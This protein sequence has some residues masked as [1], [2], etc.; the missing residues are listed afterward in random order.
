MQSTPQRPRLAIDQALHETNLLAVLVRV[1]L[2]Q[3]NDLW[4]TSKLFREMISSREFAVERR[5]AGYLESA[6][7]CVLRETNFKSA[8][9]VRTAGTWWELP[10]MPDWSHSIF[11][12]AIIAVPG[13]EFIVTG[14]YTG[15]GMCSNIVRMLKLGRHAKNGTWRDAPSMA[16]ARDSVTVVKKTSTSI[17]V[18]GGCGAEVRDRN[19]SFGLDSNHVSYSSSDCGLTAVEEYDH[20]SKSWVTRTP[21]P[22][23]LNGAVGGLIGGT[24]YIAGGKRTLP[25][26]PQVLADVYTY[27]SDG[28]SARSP[29]PLPRADCASAVF[30]DKLWVIGGRRVGEPRDGLIAPMEPCAEVQVYEASTDSWSAG[31]PL[32]FVPDAAAAVVHDGDLL[33]FAYGHSHG[34]KK[35]VDETKTSYHVVD[36][37][38]VLR[39]GAD[40]EWLE[41]P[42]YISWSMQD[43]ALA[44]VVLG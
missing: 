30:Q 20:T 6:L 19:L 25:G 42:E 44:S 14:G 1:P 32:P 38:A 11:S 9:C 5:K 21:L 15:N 31:T 43:F 8:C 2:E 37:T 29:M 36:Q 41:M 18:I 22:V 40:G 23:A 3:H 39:L 16:F 17:L 35:Y 26:S 13:K 34:T 24:V 7:V 33:V 27:S 12:P 4:A 10:K 28:W